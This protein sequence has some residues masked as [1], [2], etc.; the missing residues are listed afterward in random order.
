MT[1]SYIKIGFFGIGLFLIQ[2]GIAQ[3][4]LV[5]FWQPMA[6]LNYKVSEDYYHNF[7]LTNR[8]F[9]YRD[10]IDVRIRQLDLSHFSKLKIRDNQSLSLGIMWRNTKIF[11][12]ERVN[13][14]RL[15]E[16]YNINSRGNVLRFGYRFRAEQ[17]FSSL[18]DIYRFRNRVA[19][20]FPLQ[21]QT[22]DIGESYFLGSLEN[23]LSVAQSSE[24]IHALRFRSG[25]GWQLTQKSNLQFVVQYR[26]IDFTR[27]ALH[28][29]LV[30][31]SL[32]LGI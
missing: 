24:P 13:E 2:S 12:H 14:F 4:D 32:N 19:L 3:E 31:T 11:D 5:I 15:T 17:R 23:V 18:I 26:L 9:I 6:A 27:K 20:D 25:V 16:Q 10:E 22:L 28:V 8:N 1:T 21:G 30:E 7:S 29:I